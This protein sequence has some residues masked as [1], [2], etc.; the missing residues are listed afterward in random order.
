MPFIWLITYALLY[1][2]VNGITRAY[3]T[4]R[5]KKRIRENWSQGQKIKKAEKIRM[6]NE[7]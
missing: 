1:Y 5:A 2:P 7:L 6:Q 3:H 4:H